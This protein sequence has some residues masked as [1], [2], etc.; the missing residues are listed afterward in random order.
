MDEPS[1]DNPF[2][3]RAVEEDGELWIK[4]WLVPFK[5]SFKRTANDPGVDAYGTRFGPQTDFMLGMFNERPQ[6]YN[7]GMDKDVGKE[8]IGRIQPLTVRSN[9]VWQEAQLDK[10]HKYVTDVWDMVKEGKLFL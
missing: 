9:G 3:I 6:L 4:G 10:Q 7:H 5:H 8:P 2:A 1:N